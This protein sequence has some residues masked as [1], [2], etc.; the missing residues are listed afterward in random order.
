MLLLALFRKPAFWFIVCPLF[1]GALIYWFTLTKEPNPSQQHTNLTLDESVNVHHKQSDNVSLYLP[2]PDQGHGQMIA[3]LRN[4]LDQAQLSFIKIKTAEHW[5]QYQ[6][7]IH[8]GK[9]GVYLTAPHY[10]AWLIHK[11]QF[12]PLLRLAK[13]IKFVIAVERAKTNFFEI[14][15]LANR[16]ICTQRA[17]NLDYLLVNSVFQNRL[18]SASEKQVWSVVDEMRDKTAACDAYAI[19]DHSFLMLEREQP[20][21]FV[22]LQQ[23]KPYSN[24]VFI[25]HPTI[26]VELTNKL[27]RVLLAKPTL[28]ILTPL[29]AIYTDQ[30]KLVD[31]KTKDYPPSYADILKQF[32]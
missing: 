31:A 29:Y 13:P 16:Q 17:L 14:D 20:N 24:Y 26:N 32:W 23:G 12:R 2:I 4:A 18:L 3:D 11:G 8:D 9:P 6:Q 27:R 7:A 30:R 1:A 15:D 25:A 10:A 21:E 28:K 22:R 19:S 5:I